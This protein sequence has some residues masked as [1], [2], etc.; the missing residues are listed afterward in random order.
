MTDRPNPAQQNRQTESFQFSGE[1][2]ADLKKFQSLFQEIPA[3]LALLKGSQFIFEM[4]NEGYIELIGHRDV[5]GKPLLEALP[6]LKNQAF[7]N[8]LSKV[9]TT[10]EIFRAQDVE[11]LLKKNG[12][13]SLRS[14]FL[15]FTYKRISD[16]QGN[17]YGIFVFAVDVTEKVRARSGVHLEQLKLEAVFTNAAASLA[18]IQGPD[19]IFEKTN[20]SYASLFTDRPLVG[21]NLLEA[22]PELKGQKFPDLISQVFNTG[23]PYVESEAKALLRQTQESALEERYFDQSYTRIIDSSG[24]PYGVLIHAIDVTERVHAREASKIKTEALE[25]TLKEAPLNTVLDRIVKL[26][27]SQAGGEALASVLLVDKEGKRLLNGAAPSLPEEYNRAINGIAIGP[28]VGSCGTAAYLARPIIVEDIAQ[29][30]LWA[31]FKSLALKHGLRACWSTPIV[32]SRGHV[33]GTFALYH[34][35]PGPPGV[36]NLQL[37]DLAARTAA[38][39]IE[40]QIEID[41]RQESEERLNLALNAS[42]IGFW[43]WDAVSGQ[44]FLSE[45]LMQDWGIDPKT[46]RKTLPECIDRIH[47]EDREFVWEKIN[48]STF[49]KVP[50]DV[51]YRVV[52]P[53]GEIIWV[54][55]KGRYFL[56]ED[57]NPRRLTGITTNVTERRLAE[58]KLQAAIQSRDEF[59]SIAS[60]ELNTPLTSLKLQSQMRAR[61]LARGDVGRFSQD[62]LKTMFEADD[63]QIDRLARL[64]AD[65]LD[66][67]RMNTGKLSM[68]REKFNLNYLAKDIMER[69][70]VQFEIAGVQTVTDFSGDVEGDWDRFRIEQVVANLFTN[71]LRYGAGKPVRIVGWHQ[72]NFACLSVEDHGIGIA[73]EDQARIFERFERAVSPNDISGLGL[74]LY[75]TK[76]IVEMHHGNIKVESTLGKGTKFTL[77]LPF[78][79]E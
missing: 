1:N 38:I 43:D 16:H 62:R 63:L 65:M 69:F 49:E 52:R 55:A 14:V 37:V 5:L 10:G 19:S 47:P 68:N 66:I 26:I 58:A 74:G 48:N 42:N 4:A 70:S 11:V 23:V 12:E 31:D 7:P 21:K 9:F 41:R 61:S 32:S 44:V 39:V 79:V 34:R 18:I 13:D 3:S 77:E 72:G 17:P 71:A 8:I 60:H 22:L 50:Y 45:T 73:P 53:T 2:P 75:I 33:L 57:Q 76:Q 46:F 59:L 78:V 64:V 40:R 30:P 54:N 35:R 24:S 20:K 56:D 67:S 28:K 29:D 36:R 15:D 51:E 6:E 25:L 27:E